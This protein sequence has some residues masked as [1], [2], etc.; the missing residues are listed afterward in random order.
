MCVLL[1][2]LKPHMVL[3][4]EMGDIG[5]W[6]VRRHILSLFPFY[7][8]YWSEGFVVGDGNLAITALTTEQ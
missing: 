1:Y 7:S 8:T 4:A 3:S 5:L 2:V 6:P